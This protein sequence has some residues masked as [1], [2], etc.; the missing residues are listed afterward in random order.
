[1]NIEVAMHVRA[2]VALPTAAAMLHAVESRQWLCSVNNPHNHTL[3][4]NL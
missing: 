4:G 2:L 1:M 3:H